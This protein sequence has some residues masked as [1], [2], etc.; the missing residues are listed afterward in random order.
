M[1]ITKALVEKTMFYQGREFHF[2]IPGLN[3]KVS[4]LGSNTPEEKEKF[5]KMVKIFNEDVKSSFCS[6]DDYWRPKK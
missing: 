2:P 3:K 5:I 6:A 4:V 1:A